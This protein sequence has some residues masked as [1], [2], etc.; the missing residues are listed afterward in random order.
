[1][2]LSELVSDWEL[3]E[4]RQE[5]RSCEAVDIIAFRHGVPIHV[6]RRYAKSKGYDRH[7]RRMDD[8]WTD[9][10]KAFVRDNYP[11]HGR[12]WAGW[13]MLKRTWDAIRWRAHLLGVKRKRNGNEL[14]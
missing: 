4:I 9:A 10:E 3:E 13:S 12:K 7:V 11:N 5:L 6:V 1:M 8:V 14:C 2:R